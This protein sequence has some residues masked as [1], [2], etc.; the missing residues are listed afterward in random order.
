Q[1]LEHTPQQTGIGVDDEILGNRVNQLRRIC[2][3]DWVEIM[4]EGFNQGPQVK[5]SALQLDANLGLQV[6]VLLEHLPDQILNVLH[7]PAEGLELLGRLRRCGTVPRKEQ[8]EYPRG[9]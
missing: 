2:P 4:N 6:R 5:S 9:K 1:V 7:V 3:G 8:L